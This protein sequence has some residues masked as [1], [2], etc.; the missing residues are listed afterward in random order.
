MQ[1]AQR[2][3]RLTASRGAVYAYLGEQWLL[4][5]VRY[6]QPLATLVERWHAIGLGIDEARGQRMVR[7]L[8]DTD[9]VAEAL[10][11]E[12]QALLRVPAGRYLAP[13]QSVYETAAFEDGAWSFGRLRMKPWRDVTAAYARAGYS[14]SSQDQV[15]ADHIGC[16]LQFMGALCRDES[17]AWA[18]G[19]LERVREL[20]TAQA[21][22]LERHLDGWLP[23][24][25]LRLDQ[26]HELPYYPDVMGMLET[27]LKIEAKY[28][29]RQGT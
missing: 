7:F 5:P 21:E 10:E 1:P 8:E 28:L 6:D 12:H 15:E 23:K 17:Q 4:P 25:R 14:V 24:L 20:R 18:D 29:G 13:I 27:Y 22:F 16:M 9:G 19:T 11:A 2:E 3:Q 26:S